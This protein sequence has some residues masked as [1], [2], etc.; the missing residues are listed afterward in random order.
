M[1]DDS[2]LDR[3]A[4]FLSADAAD[5]AR[6]RE[7]DALG[8][9]VIDT[10][11]TVYDPEIPVDIFELGLIYKIDIDDDQHVRIEMTLTSPA[12]PVAGTLP[13]EV[14]TKVEGVDGVASATVD[15]VWDPPWHPSMMTE[16]AQLELGMMY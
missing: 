15:V 6:R 14:K 5:S 13:D 16:E 9:R 11:H 8:E 12:C 10:L 2:D 4:G 3:A 7:V 1:G